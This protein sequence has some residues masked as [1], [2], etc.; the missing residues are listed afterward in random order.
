MKRSLTGLAAVLIGIAAGNA[1]LAG[2][3]LARGDTT[4]A[5]IFAAMIPIVVLLGLTGAFGTQR[6]DSATGQCS[7]P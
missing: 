5:I 4:A 1:A 7:K 6:T 2:F 3:F